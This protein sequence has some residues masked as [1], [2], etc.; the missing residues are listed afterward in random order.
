MD[1]S[2]IQRETDGLV[3]P[4]FG[5]LRLT[6]SGIRFEVLSYEPYFTNEIESTKLSSKEAK[7]N[8]SPLGFHQKARFVLQMRSPYNQSG[9]PL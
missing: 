8:L 7:H 5:Y 3:A 1:K 9:I 2:T 6:I 4:G